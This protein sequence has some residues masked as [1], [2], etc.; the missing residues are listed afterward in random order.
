MNTIEGRIFD[1]CQTCSVARTGNGGKSRNERGE[2]ELIKKK[3]KNEYVQ[4][5]KKMRGASPSGRASSLATLHSLLAVSS[6]RIDASLDKDCLKNGLVLDCFKHLRLTRDQCQLAET[7]LFG[8]AK[9]HK[10]VGFEH[11]D[12]VLVFASAY[13]PDFV[14]TTASN[15]VMVKNLKCIEKMGMY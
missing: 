10:S 2:A 6:V 1:R 9:C 12:K 11:V 13:S 14:A 8:F 5:R 15:G 7:F 4:Q 3:I